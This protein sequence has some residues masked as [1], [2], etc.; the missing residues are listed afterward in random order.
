MVYDGSKPNE[1]SWFGGIYTP[2]FGNTHIMLNVIVASS[3]SSPQPN[4]PHPQKIKALWSGLIKPIGF[5]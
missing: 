3:Q 1:D 2:I 4:V 5:P